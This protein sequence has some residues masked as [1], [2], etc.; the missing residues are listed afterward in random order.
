VLDSGTYGYLDQGLPADFVVLDF[1]QPHLKRS[2][3]ILASI[4]TR[5][6]PDE[7]LMT[8]RRGNCLYT[9]PGTL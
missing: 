2:R 8:V 5:V 4:L 1:T 6:T 7:V 3:H 9:K